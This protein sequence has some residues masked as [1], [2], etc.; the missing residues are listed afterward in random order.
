[1]EIMNPNPAAS[2]QSLAKLHSDSMTVELAAEFPG[3]TPCE[4]HLALLHAGERIWPR[5]DRYILLDR[6]REILRSEIH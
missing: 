2:P 4:L 5:K 6:A 3:A 1:M